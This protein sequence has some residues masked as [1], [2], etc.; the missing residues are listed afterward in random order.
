M[1]PARLEPDAELSHKWKAEEAMT[2][3]SLRG[4]V[5]LS[6]PTAGN[7]ANQQSNPLRCVSNNFND[8][9]EFTRDA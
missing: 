8:P 4:H 1:I 7:S 3:A 6:E 5:E 9:I 2:Q